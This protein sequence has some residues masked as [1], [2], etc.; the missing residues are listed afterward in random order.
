MADVKGQQLVKR[1]MEI[2]AAG[3]H[4]LLMVARRALAKRCWLVGCLPFAGFNPAGEL[5]DYPNLQ[6][7]WSVA[8]R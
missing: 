4:N 6:H 3:R 2:A 8:G 7:L 5:G 1:A